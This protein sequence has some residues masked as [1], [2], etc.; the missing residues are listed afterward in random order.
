MISVSEAQSLIQQLARKPETEYS[1]LSQAYGSV[2]S[3]DISTDRDY[4][5]FHRA[6][7]DGYAF[8]ADD[9]LVKGIRVFRVVEEVYAGDIHRME[10][11]TG[12]C[13]KIMTG[14]ATPPGANAIVKVEDSEQSGDHVTFKIHQLKKGQNIAKQGEDKKQGALLLKKGTMLAFAEMAALAV[15]G[16][17]EVPVYRPL[18][19]A[20]ISTGNEVVPTGQTVLSHQIR[21]SNSWTLESFLQTYHLSVT[22]KK[23]VPDNKEI[24]QKAVEEVQ[25]FDL[26]LM[27]GGVSMGDADYVPEVLARLGIKKVFHKVQVK[28]G[29][30]I[31]FGA[32][33]TGVVFG[34]PGNP[35]SVQVAWK[36]FIEPYLRACFGLSEIQALKIP[37]K[38]DR[39]KRT[40]LEEYFPC[41][42][43]TSDTSM[44]S[45]MPINGSGDISSSLYTH[46]LAVH[47][48]KQ[49]NLKKGDVVSFY[50]WGIF[51]SW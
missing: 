37:L 26:I 35:L 48:G 27:S 33:T 7:M 9:F 50:P 25:H 11:T 20:I 24:L 39:N 43:E 17:T 21:D 34:L 16:K 8:A 40:S 32:S 22:S 45:E 6:A 46:G 41:I 38:A 42:L 47:E 4:P 10:I 36:I 23:L 3:E 51:S 18:K 28:P 12:E 2:L 29:K 14:A 1:E 44:I 15:V 13:Y 30:P 49:G 19:I 5:P 31:W